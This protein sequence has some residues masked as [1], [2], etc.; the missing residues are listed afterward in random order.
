[1][2]FRAFTAFVFI[3]AA[4]YADMAIAADQSAPN[5][6]TPAHGVKRIPPHYP[7]KAIERGEEGWVDLGYTITP[8]GTT[9][10]IR[11]RAEYPRHVFTRSAVNALAKWVYTPR[12]ENG[13]PVPQDN[14]HTVISFA[15]ADSAAISDSLQAQFKAAQDAVDAEQ[16]DQ[17]AQLIDQLAAIEPLNLFELASI[18]RMRGRVTFGKRQFAVAADHLARALEITTR[19][20]PEIRGQ[21][22]ELLIAATINGGQYAAALADQVR[23]PFTPREQNRELR[24]ALDTIRAALA[25]GRTVNLPPLEA[26][27]EP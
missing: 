7:A 23:W 21:I 11:V 16:W 18:E 9:S 24:H 10:G 8:E 3:M 22:S 17:A 25:T 12:L 20:S 27:D 15:L 13:I 19:F 5:P 2:I 4:A 6:D 26:P 14:N 1:M